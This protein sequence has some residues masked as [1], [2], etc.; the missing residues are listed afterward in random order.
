MQR[1]ALRVS[2]TP[3]TLVAPTDGHSAWAYASD[4][5]KYENTTGDV[6]GSGSSCESRRIRAVRKDGVCLEA[7][8]GDNARAL[9]PWK[10]GRA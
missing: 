7:R 10:R 5:R 3:T 1:S 2:K 9:Q 4:G 8:D 6:N